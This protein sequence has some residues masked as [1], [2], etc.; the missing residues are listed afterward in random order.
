MQINKSVIGQRNDIHRG[1]IPKR[2]QEEIEVDHGN[3]EMNKMPVGSI[4]SWIYGAFSNQDFLKPLGDG[5]VTSN[6][7]YQCASEHIAILVLSAINVASVAHRAKWEKT[8]RVG[9]NVVTYGGVETKT[10]DQR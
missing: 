5:W 3:I 6:L 8:R 2:K 1:S 10:W 7:S 9:K 4:R